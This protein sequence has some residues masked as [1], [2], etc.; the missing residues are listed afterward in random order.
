MFASREFGVTWFIGAV[1]TVYPSY[2][3]F[4]FSYLAFSD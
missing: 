1:G 3:Q 4:R 2:S